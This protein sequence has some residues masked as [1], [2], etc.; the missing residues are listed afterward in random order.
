M[1]EISIYDDEF[2]W[3]H[4]QHMFNFFMNSSYRFA[5]IEQNHKEACMVSTF[6]GEDMKK[7]G[8]L[9][10]LHTQDLLDKLNG[11]IPVHAFVNFDSMLELHHPHTHKG[12]EVLLYQAN[13]EWRPEWYGET[14]FYQP[15]CKEIAFMNLYTPGRLIWFDGDIPHSARPPSSVSPFCRFTFSIIFDKES[16]EDDDEPFK[17]HE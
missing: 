13:M 8:L 4:R 5:R 11:R 7:L 9:E 3:G 1:E 2:T 14:C 15:D 10:N 12:Q 17:I 6:T 16:S